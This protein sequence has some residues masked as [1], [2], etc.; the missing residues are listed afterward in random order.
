MQPACRSLY[1]K[2]QLVAD[3]TNSIP[4]SQTSID[5]IALKPQGHHSR[6]SSLA[7]SENTIPSNTTYS[8]S[9]ATERCT[10]TKVTN[11]LLPSPNFIAIAV[12]VLFPSLQHN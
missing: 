12:F 11:Q 4:Q 5:N 6:N 2:Y 9:I 1:E 7:L 3:T 8:M 10:Q